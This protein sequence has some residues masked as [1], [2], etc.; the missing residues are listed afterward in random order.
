VDVVDNSVVDSLGKPASDLR[1][2]QL[3]ETA[4]PSVQQFTITRK[5][6]TEIALEKSGGDW[7]MIKPE[8]M[9][10]D[11]ST[12]ED[13]ISSVIN[14]T[15]VAFVDQPELEMGLRKP[16]DTVTF[17]TTPPTTQTTTA[18]SAMPGGVTVLFGGYDDLEKKNVFA[19]I[20]DGTIVKVAASVLDS[21]NKKPFELRDKTVLDFDPAKVTRLVIAMNQPATTQPTTQPAMAKVT[22]LNRRVKN[23]QVGPI[24]PSTKPTSAPVVQTDWTV[25]APK[26]V[27][28]DDSKVTSLLG[29][30]HPLKADKYLEKPYTGKVVKK[31]TTSFTVTGEVAPAVLTLIDP[32]NDAAL[33]GS[34]NGLTFEMP[35]TIATDLSAEFK[36]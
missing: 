35:R 7:K 8:K 6:G 12:V 14:M 29:Q 28:A 22:E 36:K 33:V 2:T 34:Y 24:L 5:D 30:F 19:E 27:D 1:K 18:P 9:P 4:S 11:Q 13:L 31:F 15:P 3:F 23:L 17:S 21:L 16:T 25:N 32:G 26:P 10:A 20:P